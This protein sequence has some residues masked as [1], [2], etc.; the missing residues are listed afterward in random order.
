MIGECLK[1]LL[2]NYFTFLNIVPLTCV[3]QASPLSFP[4]VRCILTSESDHL[5][6]LARAFPEAALIFA[7]EGRG[8]APR[9]AIGDV[10]VLPLDLPA[11]AFVHAI[12]VAMEGAADIGP[13]GRTERPWPV[14]TC[15]DE[16]EPSAG[17]LSRREREV[18]AA[19]RRGLSNKVI[20]GEMALSENTVKI[21][22][23]NVLRKLGAT[24]RTMAALHGAATAGA[25]ALHA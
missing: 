6:Q 21:H 12:R 18:L 9:G 22:V 7:F 10:P 23:R 1:A 17:L 4:S 14:E 16:D 11:D 8:A 25:G 3:H 15:A 2:G 20:A 13:S 19:L 5:S 24:N